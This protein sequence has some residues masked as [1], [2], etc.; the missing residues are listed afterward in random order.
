MYIFF[1]K[2]RLIKYIVKKTKKLKKQKTKAAKF[3]L[4]KGEK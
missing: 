3:I 2:N 1:L 4:K